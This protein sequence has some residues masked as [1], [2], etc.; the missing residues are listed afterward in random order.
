MRNAWR[1]ISLKSKLGLLILG[2]F[3]I[4]FLVFGVL[5]N[6]YSIETIE[7]NAIDS[8][9][10]LIDQVSG[11]LN[12]YFADLIR[13]T[14]PLITHPLVT[15]FLN[16]DPLNRYDQFHN[17]E[18]IQAELFPSV[19]FNRPEVYRFSLLNADGQSISTLGGFNVNET[20]ASI[21]GQ[22]K[23]DEL[24]KVLGVSMD[25][26]VPLLGFV[27]KI[28]DP[29]S[30][31]LKGLLYLELNVHQ[32]LAYVEN[33][34]LGE[35]GL[36]W[37]A[38]NME[39]IVSHPDRERIGQPV[40]AQLAAPLQAS[41]E[42]HFTQT[43]GGTNKLF[44]FK[45]TSETG[46]K[47]VAEVPKREL[48]ERMSD[49]RTVTVVVVALLVVIA[50]VVL[51]SFSFSLTKSLVQLQKLM[52][53]AENGDLG[54][55][56]TVNLYHHEVA[57]LNLS[58][59]N[60]VSELKRLVDVQH[61]AELREKDYEI[62][63]RDSMV[64]V[65]QAQINPHFLY[66]TLEVINAHAVI[67]GA[68]PIT[69]MTNALARMFHYNANHAKRVVTLY[70]EIENVK[71]YF[72]IYKERSPDFRWELVCGE[73][74]AIRVQAV[75]IML[76]PLVENAMK[77]GYMEHKLKPTY[78]AITG[79]ADDGIYRLRIA[80]RGKG[81]A[82]DVM[83]KYNAAF[84]A[85]ADDERSP[86]GAI[87]LWNVHQRLVYT[88][89]RPFGLHIVSSDESGTVVEIRLPFRPSQDGEGEAHV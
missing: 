24:T 74:E 15:A 65:L 13:T 86:E 71:T 88:F 33:F 2:F 40:P 84:A 52:K 7:Q 25:E 67:A 20:F 68:K 41:G 79:M 50:I 10:K 69:R 37:I 6:K 61:Q 22:M 51:G 46:W 47:L 8:N 83:D 35:S 16:G 73:E 62:R 60:M 34:K 29:S 66:N 5:W 77:H 31:S 12:G 81:M 17:S 75:P 44:I 49:L 18:R 14:S 53:R 23:E 28:F 27:R 82:P 11:R 85:D 55:V 3:G 9:D 89:G 1:T 87:G 21:V 72:W 56:S 26:P 30:K 45:S 57:S 36:L 58:F 19:T 59:N 38:D 80:D 70:E 63:K 43:V 48:T 39:R 64:K 32:V 42:G 54:V 76:Q 4:P 78:I